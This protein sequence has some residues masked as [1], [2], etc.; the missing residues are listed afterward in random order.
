MHHRG[1]GAG[2]AGTA[3]AGPM[4]EAKLMNL[5]KGRLQK[6]WLSNN[7][8]V[9]FTRSRVSAASWNQSW[10]ASDAT[11]TGYIHVHNVILQR[12]NL[13][14]FLLSPMYRSCYTIPPTWPPLSPAPH[15][16]CSQ[17]HQVSKLAAHWMF[18]TYT[19]NLSVTVIISYQ[20]YWSF[21]LSQWLT[22]LDWFR[23][24]TS[25]SWPKTP[26]LGQTQL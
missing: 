13:C 9:K 2:P 24:T 11:V 14:P 20:F 26:P 25:F 21:L 23:E 8:S 1:A 4:L 10:Y 16:V 15:P 5:I 3:A 22:K 17:L 18:I 19:T 6:F 7:F 12:I